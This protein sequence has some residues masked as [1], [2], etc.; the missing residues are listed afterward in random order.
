MKRSL[1]R[2]MIMEQAVDSLGHFFVSWIT[3]VLPLKLYEKHPRI[4]R[5]NH[6]L[7]PGA[8]PKVHRRQEPAF[9]HPFAGGTSLF[10]H[11]KNRQSKQK[12][13]SVYV[14]STNG[15]YRQHN[16]CSPPA[17]CVTGINTF[18]EKAGSPLSLYNRTR[19][20]MEILYGKCRT[21][22]NIIPDR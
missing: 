17:R 5:K 11:G 6:P 2:R 9:F 21:D 4:E 13:V 8:V 18:A 20:P 22:G 12:T 14:L 3:A 10:F 15:V 7:F 16:R 19:H 1:Y